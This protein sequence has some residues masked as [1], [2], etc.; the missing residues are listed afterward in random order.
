MASGP[1]GQP[2]L[3]ATALSVRDL[4]DLTQLPKKFHKQTQSQ[5]ELQEWQGQ[6]WD[7]TLLFLSFSHCWLIWIF[8]SGMSGMNASG[9]QRA[10]HCALSVH[11][12]RFTGTEVQS[13]KKSPKIS[14]LVL[15]KTRV[16]SG[17]LQ[18]QGSC[19]TVPGAYAASWGRTRQKGPSEGLL[20]SDLLQ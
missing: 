15:S 5:K 1:R 3:A 6:N 8:L 11:T 12:C 13:D 14:E 17:C 20:L 19:C 4:A 7:Q 18:I 9:R 10:H 2:T 16:P